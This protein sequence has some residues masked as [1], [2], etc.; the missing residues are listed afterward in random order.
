M[1]HLYKST[2]A[3]LLLLP[4]SLM[5]FAAEP[6]KADAPMMHQGMGMG[7]GMHQGMG[8]GMGMMGGMTEEQKT[9][10][11]RSMQEHML[12][13]HDLSNQILSEKDAAKKEALKNQ[14]LEL[15]KAHHA[16]MMNHSQHKMQEPNK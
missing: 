14:Q 15:M 11:M 16:Q 10:H 5:S 12:M 3:L 9:E 7:M 1:K 8:M 2:A 4:I 13:M 6:Q